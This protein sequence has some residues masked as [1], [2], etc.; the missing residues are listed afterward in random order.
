MFFAYCAL[1]LA[2]L[3]SFMSLCRG[4]PQRAHSHESHERRRR[5]RHR[6]LTRTRSHTHSLCVVSLS[7]CSVSVSQCAQRVCARA[8]FFS[9]S[10]LVCVCAQIAQTDVWPQSRVAFPAL[11]YPRPAHPAPISIKYVRNALTALTALSD[12]KRPRELQVLRTKCALRLCCVAVC[13][14]IFVFVFVF[15]YLSHFSIYRIC[16]Y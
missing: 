9:L 3:V 11:P 6:S 16:V 7:R 13:L 1:P 12:V 15:A 8:L 14:C 4:N 2:L 5:C 10:D